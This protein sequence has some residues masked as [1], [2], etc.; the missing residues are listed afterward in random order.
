MLLSTDADYQ[1]ALTRLG[2]LMDAP[3]GSAEEAELEALSDALQAYEDEHYPIGE[4]TPGAAAEFRREQE[5]D[6]E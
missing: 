1:A 2:D 3:E 4:P 5:G 6:G